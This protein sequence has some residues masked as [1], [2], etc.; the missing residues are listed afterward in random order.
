MSLV[1]GCGVWLRIF[2]GVVMRRG[3]RCWGAAGVGCEGMFLLDGLRVMAACCTFIW[4]RGGDWWG[5]FVPWGD[6][7]ACGFHFS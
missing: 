4:N 2:V 1:E 5:V 3:L 6:L 7:G